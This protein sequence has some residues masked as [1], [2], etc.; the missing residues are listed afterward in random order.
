MSTATQV[1]AISGQ[2]SQ[3]F[4]QIRQETLNVIAR[5]KR[6]NP[7]DPATAA[8]FGKLDSWRRQ[9]EEVGRQL[10]R[11]QRGVEAQR[12]FVPAVSRGATREIRR[13]VAYR[14]NQS[15]D[16]KA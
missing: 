7:T 2:L 4:G 12:S 3:L 8:Y 1:N 9:V 5:G 6:P 13:S 16:G 10:E 14:A 15:L 11:L